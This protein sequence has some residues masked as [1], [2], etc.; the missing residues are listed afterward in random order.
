MSAYISGG[1]DR[2]VRDE[3]APEGWRPPPFLGFAAAIQ[4]IEP[5]VWE[6]DQA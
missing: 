4:E 5:K 3:P 6:G 2:V 1:P